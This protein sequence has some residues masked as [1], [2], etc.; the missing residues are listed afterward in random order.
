MERSGIRV[1]VTVVRDLRRLPPEVEM[2][3]F[4]VVQESLTNI[5]RHSGSSNATIRLAEEKGEV[6]LQVKDQGRGMLLEGSWDSP[7]LSD[8]LGVGILGMRQRLR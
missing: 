6:V 8:S 5:H 2:S 7:E 1:E 4:R 3:L